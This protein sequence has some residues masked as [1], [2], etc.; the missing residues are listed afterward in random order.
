MSG[1]DVILQV[2]LLGSGVLA[3]RTK[4]LTRVEVELHMLLVVA[5][6]SRLVWTVGA[7]QGLG[8]IVNLSGMACHLMLIGSQVVAA[9][10]FERPFTCQEKQCGKCSGYRHFN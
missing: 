9:V 2:T 5:A 7:A 4:E 8:P 3:N 6:I 10:T 1:F